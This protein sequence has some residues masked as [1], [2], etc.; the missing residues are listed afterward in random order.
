MVQMTK[1]PTRYSHVSSYEF[2]LILGL[3]TAPNRLPPNPEVIDS[4]REVMVDRKSLI[5]ARAGRPVTKQ[6]QLNLLVR[7][8]HVYRERVARLTA[9]EFDFAA[10][11]IHPM[12]DGCIR[13]KAYEYLVI[14][15]SAGSQD[16]GDPAAQEA[17]AAILD[18][19]RRA[20]H[21]YAV[22]R[23]LTTR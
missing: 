10:S 17:I 18:F 3:N 22:N 7:L 23:T 2:D 11:F 15:G 14:R 19:H 4:A 6:K 1:N 5:D 13:E 9:T 21:A 20:L 8:D 12:L 16:I